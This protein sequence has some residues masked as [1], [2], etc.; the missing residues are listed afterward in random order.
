MKRRGDKS[1]QD[2][3]EKYVILATSLRKFQQIFSNSNAIWRR[4][5]EQVGEKRAGQVEGEHVL[6]GRRVDGAVHVNNMK[7]VE[8]LADITL[9][10]FIL[11]WS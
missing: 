9:R 11:L 1:C 7:C 5:G 4:C 3:T 2:L 10:T 8:A 6:V